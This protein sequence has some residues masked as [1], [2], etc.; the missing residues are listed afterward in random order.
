MPTKPKPSRFFAIRCTAV[1]PG[2][3]DKP[4]GLKSPFVV[5]AF[6]REYH[7]DY[8]G[9]SLETAAY[10]TMTVYGVRDLAQS[11]LDKCAGYNATFEIVE[12]VEKGTKP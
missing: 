5:G 11:I 4:G 3:S 10:R 9:P 12:F 8:G 6:M 7:N 1:G 2:Y